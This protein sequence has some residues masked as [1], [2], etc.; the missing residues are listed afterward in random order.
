MTLRA[1]LVLPL[2]TL[3][4]LAV[5][6][7][8][9]FNANE[10]TNIAVYWGQ[11]SYGQAKSQERLS[12]YCANSKINVIPLAFMNGIKTP[13]TNFANAGDNCTVYAGTQ[14]LNC[15]Q[16][17]EDIKTCQNNGKTILLSLGGATYTEGGFSS[18]ADAQAVATNVWNLFGPNTATANRPF[19]S[20]VIDGFDFDFESSTTN[21]A[22]FAAQL[23]SLMDAATGSSGRRYYLSAAPQCPYP[24]VAD[25]DI[26]VN[27]A[28]DL[29]MVQFYNNYCG[30][31][32]YRP[33]QPNQW[34]YNFDTWDNW[35]Q[36]TSKNKNVKVLIGIPANTGAGGGYVPASAISQVVAYSKQFPS[37]GGIMMWDMSQ[38]YANAGFLDG[39]YSALTAGGGGGGTYPPPPP[40]YTTTAK[41][42]P[43][44]TLT[45][46]TTVSSSTISS[47]CTAGISTVTATVTVT[48]GRGDMATTTV[49]V[50]KPAE[51]TTA[52]PAPTPTGS[53][54]GGTLVD[55][56]GQ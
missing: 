48:V 28:L 33:G 8:A 36:Q 1:T 56:W 19:R 3:L 4:S 22:P 41:P 31:S 44:T 21:M 40:T 26:L 43:Q 9:G 38:L 11:N 53:P 20:A 32:S 42:P 18:A 13:I 14:L 45:T 35:A 30:V 25:N 15:P 54:G 2:V 27:V 39:V 24:D 6:V 51:Q 46:R 12:A 10:Q 17:E 37:F 52:T 7:S 49:Y 50:T 23:R 55:Q 5:S 47:S 34:N 16:L 29:V